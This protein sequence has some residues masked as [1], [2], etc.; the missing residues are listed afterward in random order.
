MVKTINYYKKMTEIWEH[1][2]DE[3]SKNC[4]KYIY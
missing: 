3:E 4:L 2:Q 1:L